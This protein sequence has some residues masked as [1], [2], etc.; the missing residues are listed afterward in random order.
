MLK[1][2]VNCIPLL[3]NLLTIYTFFI[4]KKITAMTNFYLILCNVLKTY[5]EVN[6]F[7]QIE[8]VKLHKV[9]YF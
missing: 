1:L 8:F 9:T 7:E 3:T 6:Y 2:I 4:V 5:K